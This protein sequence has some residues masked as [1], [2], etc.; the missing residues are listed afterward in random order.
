MTPGIAPAPGS[1][2]TPDRDN[3]ADPRARSRPRRRSV[4]IPAETLYWAVLDLPAPGGPRGLGSPGDEALRYAFEPHLPAPLHEI[5]PRFVRV[6]THGRSDAWLACGAERD[7][8][9]G[10]IESEETRLAAEHPDRAATIESVVPAAVPDAIARL[11]IV[12]DAALARLEFRSGDF[13]SPSSKR[14]RAALAWSV[15]GAAA[16]ASALL[17]IGLF[18]G[19][20]AQEREARGAR[21]ATRALAAHALHVHRGGDPDAHP[22]PY[23]ASSDPRL[24]LAAELRA[25]EQSLRARDASLGLA[26]DR[27]STYID[28]LA[29]WP[30][31][32]AS[33]VDELRIDQASAT[34][35]GLVREAGD[36]ERIALALA[37]HQW[38][39]GAV[40]ASRA[41]QGY[42]MSIVL[43]PPPPPA[44]PEVPPPDAPAP[45]EVA[46]PAVA[47]TSMTP[48][49]A[50]VANPAADGGT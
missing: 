19:A 11:V 48:F 22:A 43:R 3:H 15:L 1:T 30:A 24:A 18:A 27:A 44:P 16:C 28:L 21:D 45:P 6:R 8:L 32:P 12:D 49:A 25:L 40:Q 39:I 35:R 38:G 41:A 14:G 50:A 4:A 2:P 36:A 47:N 33:R 7:R 42:T 5:E 23:P 31:D 34:V 13:E 20:R 17:T 37:D 9:A 10:M 29:A 26:S 46:P